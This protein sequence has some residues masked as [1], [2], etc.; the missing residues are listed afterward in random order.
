MYVK[1]GQVQY[2]P[3]GL[4]AGDSK[5]LAYWPKAGRIPPD[6]PR[7][8]SLPFVSSAVIIQH[9]RLRTK[10]QITRHSNAKR[11]LFTN[12]RFTP[13]L[14][15]NFDQSYQPINTG[16]PTA[17][18]TFVVRSGDT[19]FSIARSVWGDGDLWWVISADNGFVG[20]EGF[21]SGMNLVIPKKLTNVRNNAG[22]FKVYDA[23]EAIGNTSPNL[24]N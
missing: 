10:Y 4:Y 1:S 22:T 18:S 20:N 16:Y 5:L 9:R 7:A 8:A 15:G 21:T 14:W 3:N 17:A 2:S 23:G 12:K 19:L 24:P 6:R 11:A 13:T